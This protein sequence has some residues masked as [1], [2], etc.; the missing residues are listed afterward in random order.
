MI[1]AYGELKMDN[2]VNTDRMVALFTEMVSLDSLSFGERAVADVLKRE[3]EALGFEVSEDDAGA[4]YGS[5]TGNLYARLKG[6]DP[7]KEPVLFS[8]HMDTV[9]PGTGK[10][11]VIEPDKGIITSEGNTVLGA[12]DVAGIVEIL[13]G[14]RLATEGGVYGDIEVLFTVAEEV[15]GKGSKVFD[16]S[17]VKA[18]TAFVVDMS[19]P[20]GTAAR[21]APSIISFEFDIKGKSAHAGFAPQGGINAI[22]VAADI[23]AATG[24]GLIEE[25]LTL[26]IGTISGGTASNIVS[27]SCRCTGEV[28]GSDHS[29]ACLAVKQLA[30]RADEKC[31]NAG[32]QYTFKSEVMIRAYE[33]AESDRSCAV[34]QRA[35][36]E[37]GL[38]GGLVATR[39][40]SDNNIFAERGIKGIVLSCGMENTH[41]VNEYIPI[42]DLEKGAELIAEIIKIS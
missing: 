40:G 22:A 2:K 39:G 36:K 11:A 3:L 7:A 25:G 8:A 34:F 10:K 27:D 9:V 6:T 5:D 30:E 31:G 14:I 21:S 13:E 35:C 28:R 20:A 23:I 19:G 32:A 37:L 41:T 33:T 15:Y 17:K 26:N 16:Y 38:E 18:E 42:E 24:Q 4:Q 29:A 1:S 12:D